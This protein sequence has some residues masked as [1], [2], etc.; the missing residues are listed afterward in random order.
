[1]KKNLMKLMEVKLIQKM[2][3]KGSIVDGLG[4]NSFRGKGWTES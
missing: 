1:M 3:R 4:I 2:Q